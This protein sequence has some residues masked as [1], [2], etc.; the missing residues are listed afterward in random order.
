MT[1]RPVCHGAGS[2]L[3]PAAAERCKLRSCWR[4]AYSHWQRNVSPSVLLV[5]LCKR[6]V[7]GLSHK[8]VKTEG[9]QPKYREKKPTAS[10]KIDVH[11]R[12]GN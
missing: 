6:Q 3:K 11:Y 9:N 1:I 12:G 2:G 5:T 4:A 8:S 10:A 7:N